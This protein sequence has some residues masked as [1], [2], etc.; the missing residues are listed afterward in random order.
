M[1]ARNM[2]VLIIFSLLYHP[3]NLR[4]VLNNFWH[5]KSPK[6][7]RFFQPALLLHPTPLLDRLEYFWIP[8]LFRGWEVHQV[9]WRIQIPLP[10]S[11]A[12]IT[13]TPT[14]LSFVPGASLAWVPC[15]PGTHVFWDLIQVHPWVH[16][17]FFGIY[18]W[19]ATII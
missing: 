1:F 2:I 12:N 4:L 9:E 15:V 7:G 18:F 5:S 19:E 8:V 16:P 17:Q 11:S 10:S 6:F 3:K 14:Y 13:K